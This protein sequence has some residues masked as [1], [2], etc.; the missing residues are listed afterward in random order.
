MAYFRAG[1]GLA[2]NAERSWTGSRCTSIWL[3]PFTFAYRLRGNARGS[4]GPRRLDKML[5]VYRRWSER[6]GGGVN[7]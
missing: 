6:R 5:T 7:S 2:L 1:S 4:P 3:R